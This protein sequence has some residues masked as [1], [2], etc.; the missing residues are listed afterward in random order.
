[1]NKKDDLEKQLMIK[2]LRMLVYSY[3]GVGKIIK[4]LARDGENIIR[5]VSY[6]PVVRDITTLSDLVNRISWYFPKSASSNV[7]V[8]ILVDKSLLAT[9]LKSLV[10]PPSQHSYIGKSENIHL[11]EKQACD[12]SK[13]DAI[14]LW[15]KRSMFTPV[16]LQHLTKVYI[17]D[18]TYYYS[19]EGETYQRMYIETLEDQ[20]K[21]RFLKLSMMNYR[22]L[23]D[24]VGQCERGYVFGT[25]PS[26]EGHAMDF[27]YSDG[28]RIV[29]NSIVKNREIMDHIKPH[30]LAF[31]DAQHHASPC[32]YAETFRQAVIE[33]V[34]ETNCYILTEDYF[35]P[36]LLAHYPELEDKIIGIETPGIW[37]LS[38]YEIIRM[39]LR[40]PHKIPWFDKIPG[41]EEEYNFPTPD[42]FYVRTAGSVLP[43]YLIPIVSSV[44]KVIYILGADGRDPKGDKPDKTYIWNY[45]QS[46]QFNEQTAFDTHPS[47]FRDRPYTEDFDIYC[48]NFKGLIRYG[49]SLGRKYY[50]LAPSYIPVLAQRLVPEEIL[51][52]MKH[53]QEIAK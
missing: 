12:L 52:K 18:P 53:N 4:S 24:E 19:V 49:E 10:P 44:C 38:L 27:D 11:I 13:A 17:V 22:A 8:S 43:S 34:H 7:E 46:C 9:D 36:L 48:D 6:Y 40:R 47:Y 14:M 26:L 5:H 42:K 32:L 33:A 20:E 41:H 30:L 21:E 37:D 50:S 39:V 15:D 23:L 35:L 45:S 2:A 16:V 31:G 51:T 3:Y 28:F 25:G 1:M 29:C